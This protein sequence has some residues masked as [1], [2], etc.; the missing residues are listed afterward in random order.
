M[1]C[2]H[3]R[4]YLHIHAHTH[5]HTWAIFHVDRRLYEHIFTQQSTTT[6]TT[7]TTTIMMPMTTLERDRSRTSPAE[8]QRPARCAGC[9]HRCRWTN[10][11]CAASS[12]GCSCR[13]WPRA[14][15]RHSPRRTAAAIGDRNTSLLLFKTGRADALR[16]DRGPQRAQTA[17]TPPSAAPLDFAAPPPSRQ[18]P[19]HRSPTAAAARVL[20]SGRPVQ[21]RPV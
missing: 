6:T 17:S 3:S 21:R 7:T 11:C 9:A 8:Q 5:T 14:K 2:T 15:T 4:V 1:H 13:R 20:Q 12:S 18:Y 19:L 10:C 16:W